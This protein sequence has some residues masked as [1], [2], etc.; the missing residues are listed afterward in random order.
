MIVGDGS[1]ADALATADEIDPQ[2]A[3]LYKI[4]LINL[5]STSTQLSISISGTTANGSGY[6]IVDYIAS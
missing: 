2:T 6:V 1:N 5:Y 4:D 3:G